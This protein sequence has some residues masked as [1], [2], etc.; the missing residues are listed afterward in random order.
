MELAREL[1]LR[2]GKS[3][4]WLADNGV[5]H[6]FRD[7]LGAYLLQQKEYARSATASALRYPDLISNRNNF[8][9]IRVG[10]EML[11]SLI[12]MLSRTLSLSASDPLHRFLPVG[13]ALLVWAWNIPT[14]RTAWEFAGARLV[15]ASLGL[16]PLRDAAWWWGVLQGIL[17]KN[18]R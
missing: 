11:L 12:L 9:Q 4:L 13:A 14:L 16:I 17:S 6:H 7:S 2:T 3:I 10:V 8:S 5:V 18:P 15:A 1:V